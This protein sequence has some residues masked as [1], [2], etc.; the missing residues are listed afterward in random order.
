M[1]ALGTR[2][3]RI[4]GEHSNVA[5]A[6]RDPASAK[7]TM[8]IGDPKTSGVLPRAGTTS[9]HRP[10]AADFDDEPQ[11]G[12]TVRAPAATWPAAPRGAIVGRETC[13]RSILRRSASIHWAPSRGVGLPRPV[14]LDRPIC[15]GARTKEIPRRHATERA[16][17]SMIPH[18]PPRLRPPFRLLSRTRPR[19]GRHPRRALAL[20]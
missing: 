3:R 13:P 5:L 20:V 18:A 7:R 2:E 12:S 17:V 11:F 8:M 10:H 15:R 14:P 16:L 9:A 1:L 19:S 4:L 6:E